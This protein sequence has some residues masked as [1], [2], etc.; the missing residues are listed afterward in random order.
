MQSYPSLSK[1]HKR[2]EVT[3]CVHGLSSAPVLAGKYGRGG[4]Q[5]RDKDGIKKK[6]QFIYKPGSKSEMKINWEC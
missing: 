1:T 2:N 6:I 3:D 4:E 5:P